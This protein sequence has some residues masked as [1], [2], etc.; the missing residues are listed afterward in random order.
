M[1]RI[2]IAHTLVKCCSFSVIG[3]GLGLDSSNHL[4]YKS[5]QATITGRSS[6]GNKNPCEWLDH[7]VLQ[8]SVITNNVKYPF[9]HQ[10]STL[11]YTQSPS[12]ESKWVTYLPY[13]FHNPV[14]MGVCG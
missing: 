4:L 13:A 5:I 11:A 2:T 14:Y 8:C 1:R 3:G 10:Q 6:T 12:H 9:H 7:H